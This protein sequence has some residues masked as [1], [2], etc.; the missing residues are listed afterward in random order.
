MSNDFIENR[1][2]NFIDMAYEKYLKDCLDDGQLYILL[3][4][5]ADECFRAN[6]KLGDLFRVEDLS[7]ETIRFIRALCM[8]VNKKMK[9][10]DKL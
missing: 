7:E 9:Y 1:C 5:L 10:G 4:S 2:D 6:S 3:N 8:A